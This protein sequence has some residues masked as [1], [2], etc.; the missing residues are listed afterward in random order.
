M[1]VERHNRDI[2]KRIK[3]SQVEKTDWK[4]DILKYLTMYNSTPHST[5]GKSSSELF[6]HRQFRDKIFS[7]IALEQIETNQEVKDTGFEMKMI[8]K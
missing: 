1:E 4:G 5:T 8:E 6:Y 2:L 7:V 3:I